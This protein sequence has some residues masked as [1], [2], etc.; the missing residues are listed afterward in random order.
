M[1]EEQKMLNS[2]N[3]TLENANN[4][5]K[6]EVSDLYKDVKFFKGN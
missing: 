6:I 5:L 2:F 1:H 4:G 3:N